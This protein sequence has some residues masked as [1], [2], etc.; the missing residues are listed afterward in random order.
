MYF[1]VNPGQ[2]D[3]RAGDLEPSAFPRVCQVIDTWSADLGQAPAG[4]RE[5]ARPRGSSPLVVDDGHLPLLAS[6]LQ[7]RPDKVWARG[8][9]DPAGADNDVVGPGLQECLLAVQ[10]A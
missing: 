3:H 10:L 7:D 9:V 5:V 1:G 6:H 4:H 8:A 2:L